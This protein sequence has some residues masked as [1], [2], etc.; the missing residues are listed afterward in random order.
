M[1]VTEFDHTLLSVAL[2]K[3]RALPRFLVASGAILLLDPVSFTYQFHTIMLKRN[4]KDELSQRIND[5][6]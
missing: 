1:T 3:G 5:F 6:R 4:N 2:Y